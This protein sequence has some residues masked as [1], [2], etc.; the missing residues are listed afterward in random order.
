MVGHGRI[1]VRRGRIVNS[2]GRYNIQ[3]NKQ[4]TNRED[5]GWSQGW[6][7]IRSVFVPDKINNGLGPYIRS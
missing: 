6:S 3:V 4:I 5:E 1:E 2:D 7:Y